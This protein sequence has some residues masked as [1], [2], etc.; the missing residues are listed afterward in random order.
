MRAIILSQI[1]TISLF[2][3]ADPQQIIDKVKRINGSMGDKLEQAYKRLEA[4]NIIG[5]LH[6]AEDYCSYSNTPEYKEGCQM[7][8]AKIKEL[9]AEKVPAYPLVQD[10]EAAQPNLTPKTLDQFKLG[11][12]QV[13]DMRTKYGKFEIFDQIEAELDKSLPALQQ[14]DSQAKQV[15][16]A[17]QAKWAKQAQEQKQKALAA[18]QAEEAA[19]KAQADSDAKESA[20]YEAERLQR[21]AKDSSSECRAAR[22]KSKYCGS[23]ISAEIVQIRIDREK[24]IAASSGYERANVI[25]KNTDSRI[26]FMD[27][28]TSF[29]SQYKGLTGKVLTP[30]ACKVK[31]IPSATPGNYDDVALEEQNASS[32]K[33]DI[34]KFCGSVE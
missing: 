3:H 30:A 19:R 18:K 11:K 20:K 13:G 8:K 28:A 32:I 5:G 16:K 29:A 12:K 33:A 7:L 21:A 34:A 15:E 10:Y 2:A 4:K 23:L 9:G 27:A 14:A 25:H 6:R 26:Q 22:A 24:R 17:D 31:R 1:L